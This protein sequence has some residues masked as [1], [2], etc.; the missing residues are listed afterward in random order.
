MR[1][2]R[3]ALDTSALLILLVLFQVKHMFADYFLQTEMMLTDR[4]CAGCSRA[5]AASPGRA[6]RRGSP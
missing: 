6:R 2:G 4:T 5:T 1:Q 3:D